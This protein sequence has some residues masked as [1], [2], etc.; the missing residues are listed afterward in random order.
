MAEISVLP[1]ETKRPLTFSIL[2]SWQLKSFA[3]FTTTFCRL[4]N[5]F[6]PSF[7]VFQKPKWT[8]L[9][10]RSSSTNYG[11]AAKISKRLFE[12]NDNSMIYLFGHSVEDCFAFVIEKRHLWQFCTDFHHVLISLKGRV[13]F[14][15]GEIVGGGKCLSSPNI[16]W[17]CSSVMAYLLLKAEYTFL[18]L[19]PPIS[20]F[21]LPP[22]VF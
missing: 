1:D 11:T 21:P 9:Y 3:C 20:I 13:M 22:W 14:R 17:S 19:A 8:G 10:Y 5:S 4:N 18:I 12:Y 7:A 16:L 6:P 15:A 2:L